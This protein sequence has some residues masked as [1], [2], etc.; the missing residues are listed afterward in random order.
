MGQQGL[1]YRLR[2]QSLVSDLG[3][4][5][6]NSHDFAVLAQEATRIAAEGVQSNLAKVLKYESDDE[7][8][9]V[10]TGIGWQPGVV[11]RATVGAGMDSPAG[12]ALHTGEP[13]VSNHLS[14]E[15]R[16]RTPELL[17]EHGVTRAIN[18]IIQ[19]TGEPFGVLEADASA[20][21]AFDEDDVDFLQSLAHVLASGI[22][23]GRIESELEQALREKNTL[24]DELNHRVKNNLQVVSNLLAVETARLDDA[25]AKARLRAV[26][27]CVAALGRIYNRLYQDGQTRDI[28]FGGYL[29]E[30]CGELDAFY[31]NDDHPVRVCSSVDAVF[32]D[33][34][35][36]I[37]LALM[38]NELIANSARHGFPESS[39]GEVQV[40]LEHA[41]GDI[42]VV[43]ADNGRGMADDAPQGLG[44]ELMSTLGDQLGARIETY[45]N[46]GT[47]VRIRVPAD[48]LQRD[49]DAS[50]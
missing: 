10:Y 1:E 38:V 40:T 12:Y 26:G 21:G 48:A 7:R 32:V 11:G 9:R 28:E 44:R 22:E 5:A 37:P 18:V 4:Y 17:I 19:G 23:R 13:V 3:L 49:T 43:V 42:L 6:L 45:D 25:N 47:T 30:L 46:N 34:D 33:L 27:N 24:L 14:S 41:D 31:S 36:A 20:E 8:L 39:D 15:E 35:H 29:H 16:F 2:Q 50:A